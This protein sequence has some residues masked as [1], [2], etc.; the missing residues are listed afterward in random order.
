MQVL[1][2]TDKTDAFFLGN[3]SALH[4]C[5]SSFPAMEGREKRRGG[6]AV[7]NSSFIRL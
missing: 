6:R 2:R 7:R 4:N 3:D 5:L 1:S